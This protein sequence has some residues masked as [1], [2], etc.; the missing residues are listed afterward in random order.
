MESVVTLLPQIAPENVTENQVEIITASQAR[1]LTVPIPVL[2]DVTPELSTTTFKYTETST[3]STSPVY[4]PEIGQTVGNI[5]ANGFFSALNDVRAA[6]ALAQDD[7][8][9]IASEVKI[10]NTTTASS[11]TTTTMNP[12]L[13]NYFVKSIEKD[14]NNQTIAEVKPL[15]GVPFAKPEPMKVEYSVIRTDDKSQKVNKD[16]AIYAGQIVQSS[17]SEDHEYNKLKADLHSRRPPLRLVD[18]ETKTTT[19]PSKLTV[20]KAKIP[21]RSKLTFDEKTGEPILRI[22]ASYVDS[23]L[24]VSK[25]GGCKL[26]RCFIT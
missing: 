1:N 10:E 11:P 18:K 16:G 7:Q 15:L 26:N 9:K 22:Y 6:A 2:V 25:Q 20:V 3:E 19:P 13:Q 4:Y 12:D 8:N 21:P 23:P 24:H 5:V 14:E 17:I